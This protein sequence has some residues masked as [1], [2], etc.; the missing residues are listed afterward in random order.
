M[1]T[2]QGKIFIDREVIIGDNDGSE[3]EGNN[4]S[5]NIRS[6][7]ESAWEKL[8]DRAINIHASSCEGLGPS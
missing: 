3:L 1:I 6:C 5:L 7:Q 8:V 4:N 2:W